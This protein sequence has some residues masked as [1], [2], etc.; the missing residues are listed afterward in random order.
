MIHQLS[1]LFGEG[2]Y[3]NDNMDNLNNFM[4]N[5]R[6]IYLEKT[7]ININSLN[8]ILDHNLWMNSEEYLELGLVDEIL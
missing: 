8:D 2:K 4:T 1:S 5:I 7:K 3:L 6:N